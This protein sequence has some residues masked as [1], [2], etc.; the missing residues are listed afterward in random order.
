MKHNIKLIYR[1]ER[2]KE[3]K[4]KKKKKKNSILNL[5][6]TQMVDIFLGLNQWAGG[7]KNPQWSWTLR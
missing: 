2:K 6:L 4:K 1:K 3:K 7:Q 5:E